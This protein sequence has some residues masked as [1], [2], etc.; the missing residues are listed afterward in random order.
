MFVY[1]NVWLNVFC[2][3]PIPKLLHC[4]MFCRIWDIECGACLRLLEGHDELVR[5]IR[6][7]D[8]RIVSGAYDGYVLCVYV[9]MSTVLCLCVCVRVCMCA[10][11]CVCAHACVSVCACTCIIMCVF[12]HISMQCVICI[13]GTVYICCVY[14]LYTCSAWN[15]GRTSDIFRPK[16]PT[17]YNFDLIFL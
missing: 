3:I 12:I 10:C 8:K 16:A 2:L 1:A 17:I 6:F 9:C 14:L 5:C 15:N 7:D 4:L 11:V 13:C